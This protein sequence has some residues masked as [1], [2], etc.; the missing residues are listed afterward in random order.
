MSGSVPVKRETKHWYL[1]LDRYEEFLR[2]WI[3]EG[4]KEWKNERLRAVQELAPDGGACN[5]VP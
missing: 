1:P 5:R 4:H 2:Q 3:L